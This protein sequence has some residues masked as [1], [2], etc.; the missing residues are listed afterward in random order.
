MGATYRGA[1]RSKNMARSA[2]KN[3][4]IKFVRKNPIPNTQT[5]PK[6]PIPIPPK[7]VSIFHSYSGNPGSDKKPWF[8]KSKKK[9]NPSFFC[10]KP[11]NPRFLEK[12]PW[13]LRSK[14]GYL[15]FFTRKKGGLA[16]MQ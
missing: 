7:K 6:N 9:K 8:Q 4:G 2:E 3:N 1:Q 12:I 14:P 13:F 15:T 10:K 5:S 16:F 11:K